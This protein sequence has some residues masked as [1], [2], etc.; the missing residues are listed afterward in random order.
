MSFTATPSIEPRRR[1]GA[2]AGELLREVWTDTPSIPSGR[3]C[4][5]NA[6]LG[7]I[8]TGVAFGMWIDGGPVLGSALN[9]GALS[10]IGVVLLSGI[11]VALLWPAAV[12]RMLVV[13]GALILILTLGLL[14]S[15]IEW[16]L[17]SRG[18]SFRYVPGPVLMGMSYGAL[19]VAEFGPW[20]HHSKRLRVAGFL[21]GIG[22]ELVFAACVVVYLSRGHQ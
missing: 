19:Q 7:L 15:G 17:A 13:H 4:A 5:Y 21:A 16:A 11:A 14:D 2:W 1:R 8:L 22:G 9:A 12:R 3:Y 18:A 6:F 20:S 10:A